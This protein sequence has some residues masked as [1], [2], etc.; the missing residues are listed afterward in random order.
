MI[1]SKLPIKCRFFPINT[2][3][4]VFQTVFMFYYMDFLDATS[5]LF[6]E[7][8]DESD[9]NGLDEGGV[10]FF[11]ELAKRTYK[12]KETIKE[13][14]TEFKYKCFCNK[15]KKYIIENVK[16]NKIGFDFGNLTFDNVYD[17]NILYNA[18]LR[19]I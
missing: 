19:K 9:E 15:D 1:Y 11:A 6:M 3:D 16:P 4:E 14:M 18:I 12:N 5:K 10:L 7:I 17:G 2:N 8:A 13:D